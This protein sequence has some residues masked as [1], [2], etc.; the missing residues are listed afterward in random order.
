MRKG[1]DVVGTEEQKVEEIFQTCC[2]VQLHDPLM[3]PGLVKMY[4]VVYPDIYGRVGP[5]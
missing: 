3:I 2:G 4:G 5:Y 1:K